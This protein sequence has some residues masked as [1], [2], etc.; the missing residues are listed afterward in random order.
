M[1]LGVR[2]G[3]RGDNGRPSG[4]ASCRVAVDP[5]I[6]PA[7]RRIE[8]PVNAD[9]DFDKLVGRQRPDIQNLLLSRLVIKIRHRESSVW[10]FVKP[11]GRIGSVAR[12]RIAKL[13][14]AAV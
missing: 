1:H 4:Q 5:D 12:R 14:A 3:E 7:F 6:D 13:L 9:R 10:S 2:L 8:A 11:Y